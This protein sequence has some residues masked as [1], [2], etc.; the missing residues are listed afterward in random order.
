[1]RNLIFILFLLFSNITMSQN[2]VTIDTNT[3]CMPNEVARKILIDLNDLDRLKKNEVLFNNEITG[4]ESKIKKQELIITDLEKKDKES[5]V[6]IGAN[7]EK[8]NLVEEDNKNLREEIHRL[9]TK[10]TIIEIVSA[11]FFATITYI[12]LFK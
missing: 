2:M 9:K 7:K 12:E 1:M 10:T 11:A 3:V 8:Y 5:M 4:L 6:I